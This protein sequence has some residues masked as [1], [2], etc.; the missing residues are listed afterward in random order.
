MRV[1][2]IL[3]ATLALGACASSSVESGATVGNVASYDALKQ[4][5]DACVKR[6]GEIVQRPQ[7]SG[8]RLADFVCKGK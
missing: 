5:R 3:A 6:G 8:K 7:S 2:M 4:A 1:L